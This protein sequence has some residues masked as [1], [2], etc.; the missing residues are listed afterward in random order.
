[1]NS[2]SLL[3]VFFASLLPGPLAG[4]DAETLSQACDAGVIQSCDALGLR[5]EAGL[6]VTQD[7][8]RAVGLFQ[9]ACDARPIVREWPFSRSEG[10]GGVAVGCPRMRTDSVCSGGQS[11]CA[12]PTGRHII[13]QQLW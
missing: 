1:M 12:G 7:L 8:A 4:Q 11:S 10:G 13:R 5:Y 9:K 3:V 6:D 2:K